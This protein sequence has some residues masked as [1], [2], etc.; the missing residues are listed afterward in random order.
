[1]GEQPG[2]REQPRD[3]RAQNSEPKRD[4]E[5]KR[6]TKKVRHNDADEAEHEVG[7]GVAADPYGGVTAS[8]AVTD[9]YGGIREDPRRSQKGAADDVVKPPTGDPRRQQKGAA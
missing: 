7:A 1:M 6:A 5:S 3:T 4:R 9:P 8:A 2:V